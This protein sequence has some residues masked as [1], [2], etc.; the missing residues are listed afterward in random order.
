MID[1]PLSHGRRWTTDTDE[2]LRQLWGQGVYTLK[3]L[4]LQLARS[5]SGISARLVKLGLVADRQAARTESR[6]IESQS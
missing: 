4:A 6:K 1:K 5:E 3:A 2:Q